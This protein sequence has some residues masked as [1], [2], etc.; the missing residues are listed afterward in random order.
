[1]PSWMLELSKKVVHT[2]IIGLPITQTH[3]KASLKDEWILISVFTTIFKYL[4]L[5][6][7][8]ITMTYVALIITTFITRG[9][10]LKS[11]L[12]E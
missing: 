11:L 5:G 6:Y 2:L 3:E 10:V 7:S 8:K 9:S 4:W 12:Y 1:M